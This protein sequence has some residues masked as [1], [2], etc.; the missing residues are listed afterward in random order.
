MPFRS[1]LMFV[2]KARALPSET[3]FRFPSRV[4]SWPY[5]HALDKAGKAHQIKTL[6]YNKRSLITSVKCFI[7]L[8]P[9]YRL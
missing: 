1:N 2:S 5:P 3:P 7:V 6:A 9:C 8:G 4:G